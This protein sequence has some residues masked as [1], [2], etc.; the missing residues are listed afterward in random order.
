[1]KYILA[2]LYA[3]RALMIGVYLM[4]PKTELTFYIFA[5]SIGFLMAC[6]RSAYGGDRR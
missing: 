1:M 5:C 3:S 2:V 6:H 4:S